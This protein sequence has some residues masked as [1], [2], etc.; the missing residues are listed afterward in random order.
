MRF[1]A[2]ELKQILCSILILAIAVSGLSLHRLTVFSLPLVLGFFLHEMSHKWM[3]RR[4]GFFSVYSWWPPGLLFALFLGLASGGEVI[5]A[6]P[7]A[8]VILSSFFSKDQAGKIALA[9]PFMNVLLAAIFYP[10]GSL[11]GE[12]ALQGFYINLWLAVF[13]LLPFPPLDGYKVFHWSPLL[14]ALVEIPLLSLLF[15]S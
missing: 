2:S 7:G 8:V 5:F 13:N 3:A 10:L 14:W 11:L 15:L 1:L 4:Y 9:G 6:A 12:L